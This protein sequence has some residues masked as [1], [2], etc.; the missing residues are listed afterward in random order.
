MSPA[1]KAST[2]RAHPLPSSSS[3]HHRPPRRVGVP[4]RD[5][6]SSCIRGRGGTDR[7]LEPV[8]GTAS[9]TSSARATSP[10]PCLSPS[11]FS[12]SL[13][14]AAAA[15]PRDVWCCDRSPANRLTGAMPT[16]WWPALRKSRAYRGASD[17]TR[18][19]T[20][21]SPMPSTRESR[22]AMPRSWLGTPTHEPPSTTTVPAG[23]STATACAS[24]PPTSLA[25]RR[26]SAAH[27]C[28]ATPRLT[29]ARLS[30]R[31]GTEALIGMLG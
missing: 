17:H 4:P 30:R 9:W 8:A 12:A 10:P 23:T 28:P 31:R 14:H 25:S 11:P 13:R 24:S 26:A 1:P 20:P 19:A 27:P 6:R 2:A 5:Q 21:Q 22:Y 16:G 15:A 3:G 7:L 29:H 18:C